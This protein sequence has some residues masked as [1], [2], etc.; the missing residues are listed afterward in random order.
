MALPPCG[1]DAALRALVAGAETRLAAPFFAAF[2]EVLV[3]P[4]RVMGA[5][6]LIGS[7]FA[8][9]VRVVELALVE[10]C[11]G[12]CC[13]NSSWT[14]S[15]SSLVG[16]ARYFLHAAT[17]PARA[18]SRGANPSCVAGIDLNR[19]VALARAIPALLIADPRKSA[20]S[21]AI[22]ALLRRSVPRAA[23]MRP[24]H[25][26]R[27]APLPRAIEGYR[28]ISVTPSLGRRPRTGT[29]AWANFCERA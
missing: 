7:S 3:L 4:L 17:I 21:A 1:F 27:S 8:T 2:A 29:G 11:R 24:R 14:L 16:N 10:M 13:V 26:S 18:P 12:P 23:R 6:L 5:G 28:A 22:S 25:F 9:D 20:P 15:G 19:S